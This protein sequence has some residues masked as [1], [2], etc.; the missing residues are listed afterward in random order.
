MV[1]GQ[2]ADV[3]VLLAA[4]TDGT[5]RDGKP[6]F[7]VSFRDARRE[8]TCPIWRDSAHFDAC[9]DQWQPGQFYKL[10]AIYSESKYGPQLEIRK[11]RPI[12]P[13]D[14]ADGFDE[15]M[16]LPRT[17]FDP[18]RLFAELVEL[19]RREIKNSAL[20]ALTVELL[21]QHRDVL[22]T[23]PAARRNHH[24]LVGG[25]LEHV[26][27]VARNAVFLADKYSRDYPE[28]DPPLSRDL[29]VAGAILHD[30]GKVEEMRLTP[31]GGEYTAAGELIGHILL[32][33]DMVRAAAARHAV[34]PE[35]LLRLEHIIV[36]HQ[37]LAEWG[38]PKP[39]MTP[40]AILVHF[41][42]DV[43][44]KFQTALA[45]LAEKR[46]DAAEEFTS[47]RNP[48][49]YRIFRGLKSKP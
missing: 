8:V 4:R 2:E 20:A 17:K 43:D 41:A 14:K 35:T 38:S 19:A 39:P 5:T 28:L 15:T 21:E 46:G 3:F 12:S 10:R 11:I 45:A 44:A 16:F 32:G 42:D 6:F 37:R 25:W 1:E 7:R 48:L 24:A 40:E 34:D 47:T 9:R 49:G 26:A 27:S 36:S 18:P 13:E 33:R 30:I 31:A 22:L 23:Q 29:V